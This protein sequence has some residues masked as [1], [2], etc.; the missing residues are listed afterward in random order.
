MK[1]LLRFWMPR[2]KSDLIVNQ[3]LLTNAGFLTAAA[4]A[5]ALM[6]FLFWVWTARILSPERQGLA[7]ATI[8][9]MNLIAFCGEFSL[10]TLLM[11]RPDSGRGV[12]GLITAAILCGALT[13]LAVGCI[14][15]GC[16]SW[17]SPQ[18]QSVLSSYS[19]VFLTG[20]V[21]TAIA[22]T[23]DGGAI[24]LL[25]SWARMV[26]EI[27]FSLLRLLLLFFVLSYSLAPQASA[28]VSVWIAAL[29]ASL[30]C[31][32]VYAVYHR[33]LLAW[34]DFAGLRT[35][36]ADIL[37]HHILNLGALGPSIA[38]P[39]LVTVVLSPTVNAV[40]YAAW[41]LLQ[42]A[43]LVPAAVG[44][45]L[46]AT[47]S[48]DP[49]TAAQ[50]LRFS[51]GLSA[52]FG[53]FGGLACYLFLKPILGFFNPR[54]PEIA[55]AGLDW[56]GFSLLPI[57]IKYH[58]IAVMRLQRRMTTAA[59]MMFAGALIEIVAV[60]VGGLSGGLFGLTALWL[61]AVTLQSL[62]QLPAIINAAGWTLRF[63]PPV[64]QS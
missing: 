14:F 8:S 41:M 5:S 48:S 40:F 25:A 59:L 19:I 23:A 21:A 38:L 53:I 4:A 26:R 12:Y 44:T 58:Y 3:T 27:V 49:D 46:F 7:A 24:G 30:G 54:Y 33:E 55:G 10:G 61:V 1:R 6:G 45:A 20:V 50:R 22:I 28:I 11:G 51:L 34:P 39:F 15:I 47:S 29:V 9:A 42:A 64:A 63:G 56:L 32:L 36:A 17:L 2:L 62:M 52:A 37:G 60:V 57:M 16:S 35:Y 13:S 18:L 43:M 31:T